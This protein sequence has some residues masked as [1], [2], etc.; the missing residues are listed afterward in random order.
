MK[1]DLTQGGI[2]KTL[3]LFAGPMIAGNLMQQLYNIA[4]SFIVGQFVGS[5]ALASVGAAYSLMTFLNS[6][7]IGFCMGGGA[8]FS[9]Y[10]GKGDKEKMKQAVHTAFFLIGGIS[11]VLVAAAFIFLKPILWLLQVPDEVFS[12]METY[13]WIIFFGII[14]VFLYNFFAYLLRSLGDSAAPLY[15]LGSTVILNIILD[16]LLVVVFHQGIPGAAW[17]TV[18]SQAVSGVGIFIYTWK[19]VPS[20]RFSIKAFHYEKG[21]AGEIFRLSSMA[22]LQQ[23]VMN[24]GILMIQGL[25]NSF[26][27]QVMAAFAAV[28]KIDSFAY[29]PAQEFANAYSLFISQNFGAGKEERI[30][31]G[32]RKAMGISAGFCMVISVLVILFARYLMMIFISP[33]ETEIIR[34]GIGYLRIE[35]SFYLGIGFLFLLY[36]YFRG[37]NRPAI[38]LLLTV[39]SLGTRVLLAYVLAP[40]PSI[41]VWGIWWAIPIGWALADITGFICMKKS[42]S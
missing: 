13:V 26:G 1:K 28:V 41:G 23:S 6:I 33:G 40:V 7:L 12:M 30:R 39:I 14:F 31:L 21:T 10:L 20:L 11:L 5:G 36:G 32:T 22:S 25:V 18:F 29:M 37:I 16:T 4:D 8:I 24:F 38:S 15:F 42:R 2:G 9:F 27:T 34:I 19:K 17:A 3:L 35:G